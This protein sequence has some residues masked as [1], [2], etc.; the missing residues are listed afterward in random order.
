MSLVIPAHQMNC[1]SCNWVFCWMTFMAGTKISGCKFAGIKSLVSLSITTFLLLNSFKHSLYADYLSCSLNWPPLMPSRSTSVLSLWVCRL[2]MR[3]FTESITLLSTVDNYLCIF[4]FFFYTQLRMFS[5]TVKACW[6]RM[7]WSKIS[8]CSG[9]WLG[10]HIKI[11][12]T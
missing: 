11:K 6:R 1:L 3:I 5:G 9:A 7:L 10:N 2:N 8:R 4:L 12:S